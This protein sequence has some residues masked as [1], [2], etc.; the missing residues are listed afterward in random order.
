VEFS[1]RGHV[2]SDIRLFL[3]GKRGAAW[4]RAWDLGRMESSIEAFGE[5][6]TGDVAAVADLELIFYGR[7]Q[8]S[9]MTSAE[10]SDGRL[11]AGDGI[12]ITP[13]SFNS[14]TSRQSIDPFRIESDAL[15]LEARDFVA[16]GLDLRLGRQIVTWGAA[17]EFNP[18]DNLNAY[19][20]EDPLQFGE[21]I[22]N[23]MAFVSYSPDMPGQPT[24]TLVWVPVFKGALL[25]P[26][27]L[28]AFSDPAIARAQVSSPEM[29]ALLDMQDEFIAAGG[30]V[31]YDLRS[32]P[33]RFSI[34][35]SMAATRLAWTA[36]D[37]DMSLSYFR[38]F[39]DLPRAERAVATQS[40]TT[41]LNEITLTYPRIQAV[42]GDF[43]TSI[44]TLDGMGLWGEAAVFFHEDLYRQI[45]T[46][47]GDEIL[48]KERDAGAFWKGT[49]GLDHS[50]A[51]FW[52]V[53][54]QYV[55]GF[56][57]EFGTENLRDY[58][59]AGT[60]FKLFSD[61]LLLR[62]FTVVNFAHLDS[63]A[64]RLGVYDFADWSYVLFP[65]AVW[66]PRDALELTAGGL[67]YL[68]DEDTKFGSPVTG[69]NLAFLKGRVYF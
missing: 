55:H 4:Q 48:E 40:G 7:N 47:L 29:S 19:D 62:L 16:E 36:L 46:P 56:L 39:D 52:Y 5:A 33:P 22:A 44:D 10:N 50:P 14:L 12:Y 26:E 15:Y 20:L 24:L 58:A 6:R 17:D 2:D 64:A 3:P 18:T 68:G 63:G 66:T 43:A 32:R 13:G 23:E 65:Q 51:A 69:R 11:E 42:G 9:G 38:G 28:G 27:A 31:L 49:F 59:V 35:N 60:D 1:H 57:D 25:P 67:V 34:E 41:A 45:S 61:T 54:I 30:T 37:I 21:G 53:N 8:V